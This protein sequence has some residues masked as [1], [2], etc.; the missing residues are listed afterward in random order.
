MNLSHCSFATG[1]Y[2][3]RKRRRLNPPPHNPPPDEDELK[4]SEGN[5]KAEA[6][7]GGADGG[8]KVRR[9]LD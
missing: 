6:G 7:D 3:F 4:A 9:A 1:L 2:I 8:Q 5:G